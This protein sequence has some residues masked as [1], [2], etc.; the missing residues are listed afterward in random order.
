MVEPVKNL[1]MDQIDLFEMLKM[2]K[3]NITSVSLVSATRQ[4]GFIYLK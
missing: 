3:N 1:S 4:E 2:T